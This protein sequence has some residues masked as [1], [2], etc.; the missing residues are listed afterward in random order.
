[1]SF[2]I[3][4]LTQKQEIAMKQKVDVLPAFKFY[5]RGLLIDELVGADAARLQMLVEKHITVVAT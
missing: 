3:A 4:A 1:M 5:R 2:F